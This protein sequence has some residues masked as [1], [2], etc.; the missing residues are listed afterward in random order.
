MD[1]LALASVITSGVVGLGGFGVAIWSGLNNAAMAREQRRE[2]RAADAYLHILR[3][4]EQESQWLDSCVRNFGLDFD[5][6]R[7]GLVTSIDVPK[8][9][10]LDRAT[11]SALIAAYASITVAER[12]AAWRSS[13]DSV[14]CQIDAVNS[15]VAST[16]DPTDGHLDG[17]QMKAF[18]DTLQPAEQRA[19]RVLAD[20]VAAELGHR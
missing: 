11:A 9:P 17:D 8:P 4:A 10:L 3:L 16:G 19:R 12:H 1:P 18:T 20:A 13:A 14:V 15:L 2:Q 6:L 5:E 7:F